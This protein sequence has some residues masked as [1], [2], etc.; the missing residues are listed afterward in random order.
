MIALSCNHLGFWEL[1]EDC[2][3]RFLTV[4]LWVTVSE[5]PLIPLS[6]QKHMRMFQYFTNSVAVL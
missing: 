2:E 6:R 4:H 3:K 5:T 1:W